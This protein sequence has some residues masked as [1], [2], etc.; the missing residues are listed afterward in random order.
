MDNRGMTLY[1]TLIVT[2]LM[3]ILAVIAL[4]TFLKSVNLAKEVALRS[5]LGNIRTAVILY[6]MLNKRNPE[7]LREM[8]KESYLLPT[9]EKRMIQIK[10]LYLESASADKDGNPLDPFGNPFA[11]D[12]R[13]GIVRSSSKGY[14]RW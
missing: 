11:F 7:S 10:R 3:G 14:E 5:E 13:S 8:V 9:Q 1:E 6:Q 12:A 2:S 4:S